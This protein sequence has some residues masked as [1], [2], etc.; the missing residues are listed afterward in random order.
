M[1]E[2]A[3]VHGQIPGAT[4]KEKMESIPKIEARIY[5]GVEDS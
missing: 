1:D 5:D 3:T 2:D 4:H